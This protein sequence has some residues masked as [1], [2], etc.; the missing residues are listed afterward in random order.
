MPT[1]VLFPNP[2]HAL[3][4]KGRLAGAAFELEPPR[5]G[6]VPLNRKI[7][8]QLHLVDGSYKPGN[9]GLRIYPTGDVFHM[10]SVDAVDV[11]CEPMLVA[12][13]NAM[14]ARGEVLS[15]A[16]GLPLEALATARL[17]AIA[18]HEAAYGV[19]PDTS[20]WKQ[21]FAL[22][23]DVAEAAASLPKPEAPKP[24]A[25]P[26]DESAK[27]RAAALAKAKAALAK[28]FAPQLEPKKVAVSKPQGD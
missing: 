9:E 20:G 27:Q 26:V 5:A 11:V 2:Y 16:D 8:A 3:D 13:Y 28:K 19:A 12:D 23:D 1:L 14:I 25:A 24:A 17:A 4:H 7:G 18:S 15:A 21:Q 10:F 22:D 6:G